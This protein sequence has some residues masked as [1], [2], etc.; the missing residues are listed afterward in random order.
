MKKRKDNKGR[1]LHD[2]ESQRADGRYAYTYK[3]QLGQ[4]KTVY[5]WR[6]TTSDRTPAGQKQKPAL[7]ELELQIQ[8]DLTE[9]IISDKATLNECFDRNIALRKIRDTTRSTY[10]IT[11]DRY[12]R[13]TIGHKPITEL[14]YS[15]MLAFFSNLVNQG[16]GHSTA[17]LVHC[18][19]NP[20]FKMA[21]RDNIIRNN[22]LSGIMSEVGGYKRERKALTAEQQEKFINFVA[23]HSIYKKWSPIISCLFGTGCRIGEMV[24]LRWQD[25]DF[26]NGFITISLS[27]NY[28]KGSDGKYAFH[29]STPKTEKGIRTIPLFDDVRQILL[30]ERQRQLDNNCSCRTIVDGYGGF[31]WAN[32]WGNAYSA[33]IVYKALVRIV[34]AYNRRE[35]ETAAQE[36]RFPVLM[37]PISPHIL[38]HSFCTRLCEN[39]SD[40]K[41]ISQVMGHNDIKTTLKTYY[42]VNQQH[43]Q[44]EF[45]KLEGKIKIC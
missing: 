38:R 17:A 30:A 40:V 12:V 29:I 32:T 9:G 36:H 4:R 41:L 34:D 35:R 1:L 24:A 44:D 22:P 18:A 42:D 19:L 11:Y 45:K 20:V 3:N 26:A 23:H 15:T 13:H 28:G 39:V 33:Q 10:K 7:R 27:M 25:V 2:G 43:A 16:Y 8:K 31:I 21:V 5:S 14:S 37:P 6:L